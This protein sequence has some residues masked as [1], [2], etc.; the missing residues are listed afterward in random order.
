M[1]SVEVDL[2]K[3]KVLVVSSLPD[4]VIFSAIK[5]TGRDVSFIGQS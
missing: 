4:D 1:E 3:K 5:K 2:E